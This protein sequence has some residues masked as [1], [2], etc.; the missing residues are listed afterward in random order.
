MM[1]ALRWLELA[2]VG[3]M[4]AQEGPRRPHKTLWM[5]SMSQSGLKEQHIGS[6]RDAVVIKSSEISLVVV[7]G[8]YRIRSIGPQIGSRWPQMAP[9]WPQLA[10]QKK[11]PGWL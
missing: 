8:F 1:V 9:T 3:L 4:M 7:G 10:F 6:K 5:S 11:G 2:Q